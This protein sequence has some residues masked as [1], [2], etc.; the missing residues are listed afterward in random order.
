MPNNGIDTPETADFRPQSI[1]CDNL[2]VEGDCAIL[3]ELVAAIGPEMVPVAPP[4]LGARSGLVVAWPGAGLN[5]DVAPMYDASYLGS[6]G[7]VSIYFP[8]GT[9]SYS[10]ELSIDGGM[11]WA[12]W[13]SGTD[14][15][16]D[17][18]KAYLLRFSAELMAAMAADWSGILGP[19]IMFAKVTTD[20]GG[21]P[22]VEDDSVTGPP[23]FTVVVND[24]FTLIGP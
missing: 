6:A 19:N 9:Q 7:A 5:I 16:S 20:V 1:A 12:T 24:K 13:I 2:L 3:G 4:L 10:V 8:L 18:T 14:E 17:V 23:T 21:G 15:Y 11:T 22:F